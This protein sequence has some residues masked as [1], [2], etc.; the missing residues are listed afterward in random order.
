MKKAL[1]TI[2]IAF[3]VIGAASAQPWSGAPGQNGYNAPGYGRSSPVPVIKL[4]KV[5][6]E[7]KLELVSGRVAIKQDSKTYFV[8][9]P[10]WLYSFIP[11]LVEGADVKVE[12]YAR[13]L[14]ELKDSYVVKVDTLALGGKTY[15]LKSPL[16]AEYGQ[17]GGMMGKGMMRGG[18]MGNGMGGMM[19]GR[20]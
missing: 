1:V 11:G 12:G 3:L 14:P 13:A 7:G 17:Q 9:M 16:A 8:Q 19:G 2:A 18:M 5:S 20:W 10:T 4:E 15:D 6:L